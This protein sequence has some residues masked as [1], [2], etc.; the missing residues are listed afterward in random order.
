MEK[1]TKKQAL[2]Q[3]RDLE[4][5]SGHK[6]NAGELKEAMETLVGNTTEIALWLKPSLLQ[7]LLEI[8]EKGYQGVSTPTYLTDNPNMDI[9][10]ALIE[11]ISTS[12]SE[13]VEAME[14]LAM[15]VTHLHHLKDNPNLKDHDSQCTKA[16]NLVFFYIGE[17]MGREGVFEQWLTPYLHL[18]MGT[19]LEE[20]PQSLLEARAYYLRFSPTTFTPEE[21]AGDM[22]SEMTL[23][24]I[25]LQLSDYE[26]ETSSLDQDPDFEIENTFDEPEDGDLES[27]SGFM[28]YL[29]GEDEN[30]DKDD[31]ND[32]GNGK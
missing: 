28:G 2:S 30:D 31:E 7:Y 20:K 15:Q 9:L 21:R 11:I 6:L 17:L 22:W 14:D 18:L 25:A 4:S 32:K 29:L 10:I 19:V 3:I 12:V 26:E 1:M 27:Y 8:G 24:N 13:Y 23:R 16:T 5:K